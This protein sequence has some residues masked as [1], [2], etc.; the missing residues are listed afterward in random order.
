MIKKKQGGTKMRTKLFSMNKLMRAMALGLATMLVVGSVN[1][2][3]VSAITD[4]VNGII[5]PGAEQVDGKWVYTYDSNDVFYAATHVHLFGEYVK[6]DVHTHG[7]VMALNA[8][9]S[10]IGM[11]EGKIA[12]PGDYKE[13]NYVGTSLIGANST[14][15]GDMILGSGIAP[16][17]P[18]DTFIP[19]LI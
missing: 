13:V 1:V 11:R 6:T 8:D 19:F 17:V 15:N 2:M 18:I 9:L 5:Y 3:E 10:E 16:S 12:Y 4:T 14:I 7:N